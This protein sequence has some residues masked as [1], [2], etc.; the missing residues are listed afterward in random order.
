MDAVAASG[1]SSTKVTSTGRLPISQG[2]RVVHNRRRR[3]Q[4]VGRLFT[5]HPPTQSR[6]G[7]PLARTRP[8]TAIARV[9][10]GCGHV[11]QPRTLVHQR[12]LPWRLSDLFSR[13]V[14][15]GGGHVV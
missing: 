12:D 1:S 10:R 11:E 13:Y 2:F 15:Q 6:D 7:E 5:I 8:H 3:A 14:G 4:D 9:R